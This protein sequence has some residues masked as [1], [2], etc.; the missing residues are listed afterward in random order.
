[1]CL[2]AEFGRPDREKKGLDADDAINDSSV[3]ALPVM[4]IAGQHG[5]EV[6]LDL[7]KLD[8]S[9]PPIGDRS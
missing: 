7:D 4:F 1:M 3:N 5:E 6:P 9:G 8:F 2:E